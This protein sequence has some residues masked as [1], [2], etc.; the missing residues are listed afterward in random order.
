MAAVPMLAGVGLMMVCCSSLSSFMMMGGEEKEDPVVPKT[1][2][3]KTPEQIKADE[4]KAALALVKA[5]PNVTAEEV[6][7]AQLVADNA[8]AAADDADETFTIPTEQDSLNEC[9]GARY[10][11]L[12][13]AFGTDKAALGG[14][15]TTY[16]TN[17]AE[18][19]D[20]SCTL[21]DAEAQCYLDRYPAVQAYA[22]TNLKLARKHYY[23]V[24]MG[25]NNDFV[26]PP[27][28]KEFQCYLDRYPDLQDA[29]GT[30]LQAARTHWV[31]HGK[32]ES[33]DYSCP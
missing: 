15:Y 19:R 7:A 24:G 18:T 17:G 31:N 5:D 29:F 16:T 2:A 1:P 11:D 32:G 14:H 30:D 27:G 9:Y 33:R 22:G 8:Q 25:V 23:E 6:A 13:A 21:S 12:R 3:K 26:C 4:A 10:T 20:N 28:K